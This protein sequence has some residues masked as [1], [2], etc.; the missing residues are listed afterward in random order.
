MA[1]DVILSY[2]SESLSEEI[3]SGVYSDL[4]V[5][6]GSNPVRSQ[7]ANYIGI[8]KMNSDGT[9]DYAVEVDTYDPETASNYIFDIEKDG[10]YRVYYAVV[11]VYDNATSYNQY[12]VVYLS[13]VVYRALVTTVGNTPPNNSYWEVI[14]DPAG[15]VGNVDSVT[16]SGNLPYT[17]QQDIIY[18]FAK[19]CYGD[20]TEQADCNCNCDRSEKTLAYEQAG[21]FVDQ[22]DVCNQR[23]K[24]PSGERIAV[25]AAEFCSDNDCGC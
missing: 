12:D 6:G 19:T 15:L 16:E 13:G 25:A 17:I 5:Y 7:F 18:P 11:P 20:L 4:T 22:L 9:V 21:V 23:Q 14:T 2:T 3:Y 24:Y 1:L 10:W 8:S